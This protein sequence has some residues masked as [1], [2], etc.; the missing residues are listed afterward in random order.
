MQID[1][2]NNGAAPVMDWRAPYLEYLL[3]GELPL[4]KAEARRLTRRAK[5]FVLLG[6]EKELYRAA[7]GESSSDVYPSA[8]GRN[9]WARSTRG[10]AG[11][12]RHPRPSSA[13]PLA[14]ILLADRSRQ[15]HQDRV[16]LPRLPVLRKTDAYAS[17][18]PRD[19]PDHLALRS[20]GVRSCLSST[21]GTQGLCAPTGRHR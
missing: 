11:T 9:C 21:K 18:G 19:D 15:H 5:T 17:L 13:T 10:L 7:P 12:M 16:I 14:R 4:Q 1:N 3:R 20:V 6:E 8:R 2:D